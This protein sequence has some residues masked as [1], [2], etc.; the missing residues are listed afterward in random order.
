MKPLV[1]CAMFVIALMFSAVVIHSRVARAAAPDRLTTVSVTRI[2]TGPDGFTHAE[3]IEVNLSPSSIPKLQQSAPEK[4]A[5]AYF[6]SVEP[7]FFE[8][9][10]NAS[11]HR[12]VFTLSGNAE[13]E[14]AGGQKIP[15]DHDRV[16]LADDL[17][18]K[19]HITRVIG[20]EAWIAAFV[21][22]K[23]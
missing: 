22:F 6:V 15:L 8:D 20:K 17:T 14:L 3:P 11:A 13:I 21:Q 18:G 7:G 2:F 4:V 5:N 1:C 9:W 19:G 16:L 23:E 10:H 12:Y